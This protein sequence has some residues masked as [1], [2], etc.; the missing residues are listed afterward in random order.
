MKHILFFIGSAF[1]LAGT[2]RA[3]GLQT[4]DKDLFYSV[5]SSASLEKIE[6][7]LEIVRNSSIAEKNAYEGALLM[8]KAGLLKKA[9]D[10]LKAFKAGRIKFETAMQAD[11]SNP[12]FRFLRLTIQEHAP[13]VVKYFKEQDADKLAVVQ[14]FKNLEAPV[15]KAIREYS[16]NSKILR[17]E[18]L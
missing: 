1:L 9:D 4:F 15:Q 8:R 7:E 16:K 11:G 10:K 17:P 13:R 14:G 5:M 12:E 2:A 3:S 18:D 6:E